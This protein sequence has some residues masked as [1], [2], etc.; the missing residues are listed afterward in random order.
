MVIA[1][2]ITKETGE[3]VD[4][5]T[6]GASG[7]NSQVADLICESRGYKQM[8]HMT[9]NEEY[10]HFPAELYQIGGGINTL[11]KGVTC[12]DNATDISY[13]TYETEKNGQHY[14]D[15]Y[16]Y[17]EENSEATTDYYTTEH[18][19][20][21]ITEVTDNTSSSPFTSE[22]PT[23]EEIPTADNGLE[24]EFGGLDLKMFL[25][26]LRRQWHY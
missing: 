4:I 9:T 21:P 14:N 19:T 16:L 22:E 11:I 17:C 25:G 24:I 5:G 20:K 15:L 23:E 18:P 8:Q 26:R 7:T 12:P 1:A 2:L 3:Q 13:C 10:L 6:V